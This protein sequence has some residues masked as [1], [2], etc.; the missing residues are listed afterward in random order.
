MFDVL[1]LAY[2]VLFL[3][4]GPFNRFKGPGCL[5]RPGYCGIAVRVS[6]IFFV[7]PA[8]IVLL[9]WSCIFDESSAILGFG[10]SFS[11]IM[12]I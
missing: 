4:P 3:V 11:I 2:L 10:C 12:I 7:I 5:C 8:F 6:Y 9:I 1:S